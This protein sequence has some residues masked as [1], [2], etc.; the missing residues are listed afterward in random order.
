VLL[1][2]FSTIFSLNAD[3]LYEIKTA[4]HFFDYLRMVSEQSR[5]LQAGLLKST[6]DGAYK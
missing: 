3:K 6:L 5:L 2:T 1:N 4:E